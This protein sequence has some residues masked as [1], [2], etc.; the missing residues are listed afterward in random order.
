MKAV[1][2]ALLLA[3]CAPAA[4]VVA[5]SPAA[6]TR[7]SSPVIAT[8]ATRD[9]KLQVYVSDGELSF[10]VTTQGGAVMARQLRLDDLARTFPT[11][12]RVYQSS[13]AAHDPASPLLAD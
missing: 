10:D 2:L 4:Q 12:Y 5:P 7:A 11:L 13:Y 9:H 8:L 3:A 6:T 1:S